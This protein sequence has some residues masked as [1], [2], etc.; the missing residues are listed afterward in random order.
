MALEIATLYKYF[1][2]FPILDLL[3]PDGA[4]GVRKLKR[5]RALSLVTLITA[6]TVYAFYVTLR[7]CA[8]QVSCFTWERRLGVLARL[9][10]KLITFFVILGLILMFRALT[11]Y[12]HEIPWKVNIGWRRMHIDCMIIAG[13]W[14]V[15]HIIAHSI[16]IASS[17]QPLWSYEIY[18]MVTGFVLT[19]LFLSQYTPYFVLR[20]LQIFKATSTIL[21]YG[22]KWWFRHSHKQF[23]KFIALLYF[24]HASGDISP[25]AI[26]VVWLFCEYQFQLDV[27]HCTVRFTP[28]RENYE[29]CELIATY[30]NKMPDE[31][32]YYCRI[33]LLD[34]FATYTQIPLEDGHTT[35]FKIKKSI[36]ADKLLEY[37]NATSPN[38]QGL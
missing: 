29:Y 11:S 9:S 7:S 2:K 18:F 38:L 24:F 33:Y 1:V 25:F 10:G 26:Y 4:P 27:T 3:A 21:Q 14:T 36:Q 30:T 34:T 23:F 6:A 22:M 20:F 32:G 15:V 16:R 5:Y 8:W 31:F 37:V 17:A 12:F 35:I 19:S 28:S 13:A